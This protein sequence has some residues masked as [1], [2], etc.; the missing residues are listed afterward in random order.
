MGHVLVQRNNLPN[1]VLLIVPIMVPGRLGQPVRPLVV[2]DKSAV[3]VN[4]S[5]VLPVSIVLGM[6]SRL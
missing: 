3:L 6:N 1:V 5:T 2:K 4:V